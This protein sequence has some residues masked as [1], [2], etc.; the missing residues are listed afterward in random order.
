[1]VKFRIRFFGKIYKIWLFL[2]SLN[3]ANLHYRY[4]NFGDCHD[5]YAVSQ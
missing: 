2:N 3:F 4:F 5:G 1:M